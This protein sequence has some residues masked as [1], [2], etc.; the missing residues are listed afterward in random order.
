MDKFDTEMSHVRLAE[1]KARLAEPPPVSA[2]AKTN[3]DTSPVADYLDLLRNDQFELVREIERL[4]A[5]LDSGL[6]K[7]REGLATIL[8]PS[9]PLTTFRK[10]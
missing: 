8:S 3:R 5:G 7:P 6:R 1:I 4:R 10:T 2:V 9:D